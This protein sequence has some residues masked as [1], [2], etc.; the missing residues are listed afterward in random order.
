MIANT[1]KEREGFRAAGKLLARI[2]REASERIVVGV[3]SAEI[4]AFVE[5]EI[6]AASAIPMFIGYPA[7]SYKSKPY[8]AS[9]CISINDEVVHGIPM[10]GKIIADGDIVSLDCALSLSGYVA[11]MTIT[12]I[13]GIANEEERRLV[14]ATREA[15]D[16]AVLA[17]KAGNRVG[18][19]G[20]AV[21]AVAE[22][23]KLSVVRDL[24]GHGVGHAMHEPP[25]IPNFGT[26]SRGEKLE[27]N[28]VLALEPIFALG[29]GAIVLQKDGWTY[30]T[31]DHSRAAEWE[32]TII[33]GKD[34]GE[35]TTKI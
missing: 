35:I 11:D 7:S 14:E 8:P 21:A 13:V 15:R 22:K 32:D 9:T 5:K 23:Y 19:I 3:S 20:A 25:F 2:L 24:G 17:A 31:R 34:G 12:V 33:V 29:S 4:D 18:D 27:E 6:R 28:M 10:R 30:K 16:A 26:A 1:H